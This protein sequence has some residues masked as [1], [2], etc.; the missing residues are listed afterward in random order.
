MLINF[1]GFNWIPLRWFPP[2]FLRS[3]AFRYQEKGIEDISIVWCQ[4]QVN[5]TP[6]LFILF[7]HNIILYICFLLPPSALFINMPNKRCLCRPTANLWPVFFSLD[8][9]DCLSVI[10]I[11][12]SSI[13]TSISK[14]LI[15]SGYVFFF[16]LKGQLVSVPWLVHVT[17]GKGTSRCTKCR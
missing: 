10:I 7:E 16:H 13:F 14:Y 12:F 2:R 8:S 9:I 1:V 6:S 4:I 3:A 11:E 15:S 17:S 5:Y